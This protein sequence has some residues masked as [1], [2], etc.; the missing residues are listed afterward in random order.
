MR[1]NDLSIKTQSQQAIL[2]NTGGQLSP[3]STV[4]R[5]KPVIVFD[6]DLESEEKQLPQTIP[7]V[8]VQKTS[9]NLQQ[10]KAIQTAN[11]TN[12]KNKEQHQNQKRLMLLKCTE[13]TDIRVIQRL[14]KSQK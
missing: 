7:T 4:F 13:D 9:E 14:F 12:K 5:T 6:L 10:C 11:T 1:Q 3:G 2:P 8:K